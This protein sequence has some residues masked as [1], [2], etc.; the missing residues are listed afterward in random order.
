MLGKAHFVVLPYRPS[1][2]GTQTSGVLQEAVFLDTVPISYAAV[3]E[4]NEVPGIGFSD[5]N[6]VTRE[7]L[8]ALTD[9]EAYERLR[10]EVYS[11]EHMKDVLKKVFL[12]EA[13]IG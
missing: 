5:W 7:R 1:Q 2:Y 6:E 4:N 3:L 9:M 11:R 8:F 10:R 12:N 13:F